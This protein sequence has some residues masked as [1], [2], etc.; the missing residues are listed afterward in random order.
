MKR[1]IYVVIA[2]AS[3]AFSQSLKAQTP[4]VFTGAKATLK[5]YNALYIINT[6]DEKHI[7]GTLRNIS[8]AIADPRLKDKLTV[9]IIAFGDGVA[10]YQTSGGFENKLKE[11][12]AKGVIL[13]QCENTVR[14]RKISKDSLFDFISYVPSGNGEIIIRQYQGW[15]TV[16]P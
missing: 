16:H 9:E 7:T 4:A 2:V 5:H 8:N 11:L 14:E 6:A 10:V 3:M 12:Q 1:I 13:A 15:A